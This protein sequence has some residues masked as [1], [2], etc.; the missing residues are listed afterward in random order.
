MTTPAVTGPAETAAS[1]F[2]RCRQRDRTR[3]P[4]RI[5]ERARGRDTGHGRT[6]RAAWSA[7]QRARASLMPRE[8]RHADGSFPGRSRGPV[9]GRV[10]HACRLA[11][12]ARRHSFARRTLADRITSTFWMVGE[13]SGKIRSTPWPNDTLRTVNDARVPPRCW[14]MTTPSKIWMRSFVAFADLDAP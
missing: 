9:L 14:P 2:V 10:L 8:R 11:L 3:P 13:C 12:S 1:D 7:T 6:R 4:Q 5:F